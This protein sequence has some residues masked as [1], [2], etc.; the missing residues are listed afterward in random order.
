MVHWGYMS[1]KDPEQQRAYMRKWM[2][3]RRQA[4]LSVHGPCTQCRSR[5][6]LEV[7]HRDPTQK[8]DHKVW[9]WTRER[10]E[11]E[12][13]KCEVLCHRCHVKL[14]E[15]PHGAKSRYNAGCRCTE[16][17]KAN[18]THS[19][20]RRRRRRAEQTALSRN[21]TRTAPLKRPMPVRVRSG[22]PHRRSSIGTSSSLR[23]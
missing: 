1:Y 21:R 14:T 2:H 4:W 10:R 7:H 16:C 13:A 8:V 15:A 20:E 6:R 3:D 5:R 12:L 19:R 23:S 18:A 11:A 9:S 17:R 22:P